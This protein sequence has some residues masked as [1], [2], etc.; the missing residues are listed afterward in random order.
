MTPQTL[1]TSSLA[2]LGLGALA[3]LA[4]LVASSGGAAAFLDGGVRFAAWALAPYALLT[5]GL[6][7]FWSRRA[8]L[9]GLA[10]CAAVVAGAVAAY[11]DALFVHPDPQSALAFVFVPVVQIVV[12]LLTIGLAWAL[13]RSRPPAAEARQAR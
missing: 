7:R 6:S 12:A 3:T 5:V 11:A 8:R 1:R 4:L 2:L 13:H 10:G 9:A